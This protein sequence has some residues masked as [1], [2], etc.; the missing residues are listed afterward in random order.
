[1]SLSRRALIQSGA[2]A[3]AA[4][5]AATAMPAFAAPAPRGIR[6]LTDR[7]MMPDVAFKDGAGQ[8]RGFVEFKGKPVV[9]MFWA[10]WCTVCYG[11]MPKI[12]ALQAQLGDRARIVPLSIDQGG[13][14]AVKSYYRRRNLTILRPYL[15]DERIFASIMGIRGVPTAFILNREGQMVGVSEGPVEWDSPATANY[16]LSL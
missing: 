16:L 12:D 5:I 2:A 6:P 1:M 13:M 4:T 10:T 15:D 9:A 3:T 14:S 11:E 7:S 8:D